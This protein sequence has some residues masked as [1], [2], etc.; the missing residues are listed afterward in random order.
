VN[1]GQQ[2]RWRSIRRYVLWTVG[3]NAAL[4]LAIIIV[5][6]YVRE[7]EW[8]GLVK[9]KAYPNRTLWDW[10]QLLIIP[11][12]LAGVGLWFNRQQRD[13]ELQTADRRARDEALQA[14][15][16]QMSDMLIPSSK[17]LPSL[18]KARPRDSLSSVAR[19]RTLTVLPRLDGVRKARVVQFLYEAGL[20]VKDRPILDLDGADLR[21]ADLR[22]ADLRNAKLN[23]TDLR[24]ADLIGSNLIGSNLIKSNLRGAN[25]LWSKLGDA[26]LRSAELKGADLR[27]ADLD[28]A[29][30]RMALL[31]GADLTNSRGWTEEQLD[32]ALSLGGATMP[33]GTILKDDSH[34]NRPTFEEWRKSREG[35]G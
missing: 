12:V 13:Q 18:Y 22:G 15:L 35:Q 26:N 28:A 24:G 21:G 1:Q 7:W 34:P 27:G 11:A 2:S 25:L 17:E 23:G 33:N 29:N 19:A 20:I 3:I 16:D 6:G 30:L 8:T 10:L 5:L 9:D 31:E 4:V 14:Y 32:Q